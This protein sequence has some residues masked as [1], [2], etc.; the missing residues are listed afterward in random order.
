[1][2]MMMMNGH[3][4]E[5]DDEDDVYGGASVSLSTVP[6]QLFKLETE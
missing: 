3:D 2:K 5:E 4:D 1:M 6:Q